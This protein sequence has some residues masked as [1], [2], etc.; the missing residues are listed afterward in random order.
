MLETPHFDVVEQNQLH[1]QAKPKITPETKKSWRPFEMSQK[2]LNDVYSILEQQTADVQMHLWLN[3]SID[4]KDN[5]REPLTIYSTLTSPHDNPRSNERWYTLNYDVIS[6]NH[7]QSIKIYY[8]KWN[9]LI[10]IKQT[11][12]QANNKEGEDIICDSTET[13]IALANLKNYLIE[14]RNK[15]ENPTISFNVWEGIYCKPDWL[16]P[17]QQGFLSQETLY[18]KY[19]ALKNQERLKIFMK[20]IELSLQ[21][22]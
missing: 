7:A 16:F 12:L 4:I 9:N 18:T 11:N 3:T 14:N 1:Q 10:G 5:N 13:A 17:T 22:G 21:N 20:D 15:Y 6:H 8:G 19:P 2:D